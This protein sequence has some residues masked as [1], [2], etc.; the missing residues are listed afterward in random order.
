MLKPNQ[1]IAHFKIVRKIGAG[2]M[3]EVY[4]AEDTKLKRRVALK[5][6]L[7]E[8]FEDEERKSRFQREARTAAQI[9]HQSIMGIYDIDSAVHPESGQEFSYIVME[10]I[11]GQSLK[12]YLNSA[13]VDIAEIIHTSEHIANGLAA[14]H[15]LNIIHRDIKAANII[16]DETN[17]PKILDFG[18][19]KPIDTFQTDS[20]GE[21]TDTVSQELT[22]SGKIIGT[23]SYMSPEQI[24]GETIDTRSDVFSFGIL[25]YRMATGNMPFEGETQVSTMA[26][27]LESQPE[28]PNSF[29]ENLPTE[30]SRII[31]KCLRKKP[32]DRYQDTRDLVVDLRNL[33][34]QYDSD[35]STSVTG[36]SQIQP[37]RKFSFQLSP[38]NL[39]ILLPLIIVLGG[40]IWQILDDGSPGGGP[41]VFAGE[42]GLAILGFDNKTGS[43]ELSWLQTGLPEILQTDLAQNQSVTIINRD[44]VVQCLEDGSSHP[45][46][47]HDH[48][49]CLRAANYLGAKHAIS[50]AFYKIGDQIRIDARLEELATG[51]LVIAEKVVGTDPF[52]LVDSLTDKIAASLNL[53]NKGESTQIA[54]LTSSSPE[55]YRI[56]LKAVEKFDLEFYDEAIAGFK[57]AIEIDTGF[58]LPYMR[59]GMAHVFDGRAQEGSYWFM[60]AR[61]Y[62][63]RLPVKDRQL[64]D[65]YTEIWLNKQF[66]EAMIK[67]ESLVMNYPDDKETRTINALLINF[68][69]RDTVR[70]FAQLDTALMLDPKYMLALSQYST[71]YNELDIFDEAIRYANLTKDYYPD[72]PLPNLTLANIYVNIGQFDN[73][74]SEYSNLLKKIPDH[75]E[76]LYNT[77]RINI[78][79]RD[80]ESAKRQIDIIPQYHNEDNYKM[81]QYY[82][83]LANY[84]FWI[85]ESNNFLENRKN[86]INY[87][88]VTG[89]STL[90]SQAFSNIA[91]LFQDMK[92]YDSTLYYARKGNK[93]A[94]LFQSVDYP[95][96]M[97]SVDSSLTTEAKPIF[98]EA[99]KEFR[100]NLPQDFWPLAEGLEEVFAAHSV[101]DTAKLIQAY[102]KMKSVN[103]S[104][105]EGLDRTIGYLAALDGQY[106]KAVQLLSQFHENIGMTSTGF[107]Y[108]KV[109]YHLG[110]S[111]E[112]LNNQEAATEIYREIMRFW[113]NT[114]AEIEYI[115]HAR[116]YLN[117]QTS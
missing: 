25:L 8:F 96:T 104:G 57:E 24:R 47:G 3:G 105:N 62:E 88:L 112:G 63:D 9:T 6:L 51:K 87:I 7:S 59:I 83:G 100:T 36:I 115:E 49:D 111:Y 37:K 22:R 39:I 43:E 12:D 4:L 34:R 72:S 5:V 15:K 40:I 11:E 80:F 68:F 101:K 91:Q 1:S 19:A 44:R 81:Y 33:R 53:D 78:F 50:G 17:H 30:L 16:I 109:L 106:D 103:I 69:E 52:S 45:G 74:E 85:G 46:F 90:I 94:S 95:V 89:D 82:N 23:I 35:I 99:I 113:E 65:V 10:Y 61:K 18:L 20:D 98:D 76:A 21:S 28:P 77:Y 41:V 13:N 31:D 2:G 54:N 107:T 14:A 79:K 92:H 84:H 56:Y 27:I 116:A 26:K 114:D 93:W 64:L 117:R 48:E 32:D 110:I 73:A 75:F 42:N 29:N 71:M 70:A 38:R 108:L 60:E 55:A 67:M 97:V 58:A 86:A 102:E 66:N